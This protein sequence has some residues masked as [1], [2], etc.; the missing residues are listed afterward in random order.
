M[1]GDFYTDFVFLLM[2][3][4]LLLIFIINLFGTSKDIEIQSQGNDTKD[5]LF[6]F[7]G[8]TATSIPQVLFSYNGRISRSEYWLKGVIVLLPFSILNNILFIGVD[9]DSARLL[10]TII[11]IIALWPGT[12]L[13]IKR[14]H[15]RD[16]SAWWLLTPLIPFLGI[17]FLIWIIVETWFFK[18]TNG[19]N[20]FG[21]DPL[22]RGEG[23]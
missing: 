4:C 16:R 9:T 12:A 1:T 10:A 8:R 7:D 20:R 11:G 18:G 14:W 2:L 3:G 23:A 15:D 22:S 13:A 19:T 21:D 17:G 5:S 6:S